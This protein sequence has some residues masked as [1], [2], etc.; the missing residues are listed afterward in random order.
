VQ[1]QADL[2]GGAKRAGRAGRDRRASDPAKRSA[3][4]AA[5]PSTGGPGGT[6]SVVK[7]SLTFRVPSRGGHL[8]RES[9]RLDTSDS[10]RSSRK[11]HQARVRR[12]SAVAR[13]CVTASICG[14]GGVRPERYEGMVAH[15]PAHGVVVVQVAPPQHRAEQPEPMRVVTPEPDADLESHSTGA[16]DAASDH[17]EHP[18]VIH[19]A[20]P[21]RGPH[22]TACT[23]NYMPLSARCDGGSAGIRCRDYV[24]GQS[25]STDANGLPRVVARRARICRFGTWVA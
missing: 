13:P 8:Y 2:L 22:Q 17:R 9:W 16:T 5:P 4:P 10:A 14:D 18:R 24:R 19:D 3:S 7:C 20:T 23:R 11:A 21:G 15:E 1:G 25:R 12:L 6:W